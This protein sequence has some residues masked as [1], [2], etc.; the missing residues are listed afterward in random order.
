[1]TAR[2]NKQYRPVSTRETSALDGLSVAYARTNC[3]NI[4]NTKLITLPPAVLDICI[5]R[6]A[7]NQGST[8]E[9]LVTH[10]GRQWIPPGAD[11]LQWYLGHQR[12][13][14]SGNTTWKLYA[15]T[16]IYRGDRDGI[17]T[18]QIVSPG[19]NNPLSITTS[20]GTY[21]LTAASSVMQFTG[22]V[23]RGM[24]LYF[25]LTA[26]NADGTTEARCTYCGVFPRISVALP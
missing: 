17:D 5:P 7:S 23:S 12:T 13:A 4:N 19:E 22:N 6:K 8:N 15:T 25:L 20:S 1:M 10:Y 24:W 26:T 11:T 9:Y 14:G 3:D 2:F 21:A 16:G 18:D